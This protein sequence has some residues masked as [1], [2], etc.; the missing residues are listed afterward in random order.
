MTV[1]RAAL[2]Y[3]HKMTGAGGNIK[4]LAG[5]DE[6]FA[7]ARTRADLERAMRIADQAIAERRRLSGGGASN[8]AAPATTP[9]T[10]RPE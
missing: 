9:S 1:E 6:A 10:F 8:A 2:A 7:G 4:E 3:R 5:I